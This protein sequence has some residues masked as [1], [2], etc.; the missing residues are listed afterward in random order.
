M[1]HDKYEVYRAGKQRE[2]QIV[3]TDDKLSDKK[4][5]SENDRLADDISS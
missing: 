3:P 4:N 2:Q 5:Y 1:P